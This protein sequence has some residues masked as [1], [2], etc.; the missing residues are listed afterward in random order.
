MGKKSQRK[1]QLRA[2]RKQRKQIK[3]HPASIPIIDRRDQPKPLNLLTI[4]L[5][6]RY[7]IFSAIANGTH[8][9]TIAPNFHIYSP[10]TGLMDSHIQ[11]ELEIAKW[12]ICY[13]RPAIHPV[14]G[15]FNPALTTFKIT[16]R[17]KEQ[18]VTRIYR[19]A[20]AQEKILTLELWKRAMD[21]VET[22]KQFEV[23]QAIAWLTRELWLW[24]PE[25]GRRK[26]TRE[27]RDLQKKLRFLSFIESHD[28]LPAID[29]PADYEEPA[30]KNKPML[31]AKPAMVYR[32]VYRRGDE[33]SNYYR[34]LGLDIGGLDGVRDME[35]AHGSWV[36][37]ERR[38]VQDRSARETSE[39]ASARFS[40]R[41][42]N[43]KG[44]IDPAMMGD[45]FSYYLSTLHKPQDHWLVG[46]LSFLDSLV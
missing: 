24:K 17:S 39:A 42:S 38:K 26:G 15:E 16:F 7:E 37:E 36:I 1:K 13:T 40:R 45:S 20:E 46:I 4:P 9:I 5:E 11:L 41:L 10:L 28:S 8:T 43:R 21:V 19:P 27:F 12:R 14:F 44:P 3:V 33:L 22:N 35:R 31:V 34:S 18:R 29:C 32:K 25:M 23:N 30:N 6:I 2:Q